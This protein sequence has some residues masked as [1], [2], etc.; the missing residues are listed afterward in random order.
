[1]GRKYEK[2]W[3]P[4]PIF[5]VYLGL[6]PTVLSTVANV[7]VSPSQI[8]ARFQ[9]LCLRDTYGFL[10]S[11]TGVRDRR[12]RVQ[13]FGASPLFRSFNFPCTFFFRTVYKKLSMGDSGDLCFLLF[14]VRVEIRRETTTG[15]FS[16]VLLDTRRT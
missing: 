8:F 1:M 5:A 12:L 13:M 6:S 10:A 3:I 7:C 11:C 2:L 9:I 16:V 15:L 14:L 4:I